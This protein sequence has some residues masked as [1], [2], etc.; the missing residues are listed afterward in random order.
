MTAPTTT[1][2]PTDFL[3]RAT[4]L[5]DRGFSTIPLKPR[6]KS[7]IGPGATS[8]TRDL[9]QIKAW[10][11]VFPADCNAAIV[12][13][14]QI[15]ILESDDVERLKSLLAECGVTLPETLTGGARENRP[16]FY[17]KRTEACGDSC[18]TVPG[19]FEFRN[20]SQYV[21]GSGSIHP[22]GHEYRF[23][24]DA[25]IAEMPA[26]LVAA[27]R[28]L[29]YDYTGEIDPERASHIQPGPYTALRAEYLRRCDPAD[30]IAMEP[31]EV[32]EG[33][34]HY[35]LQSLA[36]LLHDGERTSE[37]IVDI[38][39]DVQNHHFPSPKGEEELANIANWATRQEPCIVEPRELESFTVG[40]IVFKTEFAMETW[41]KDNVDTFSDSWE[42]LAAEELPEQ[43]TLVSLD[44]EVMIREETLTEIFAYRG[45]GKSVL[46]ASLIKILAAGGEFLGISSPGGFRVLL[47]D[48]ELPA[49]LLQK[50]LKQFVG[51]MPSNM[52][53]VRSLKKVKNRMPALAS[54]AEQHKFMQ[55]LKSWRPDVII[56]DTRTAVFKHDTNNAEQLMVVNEFLMQL[57]AEGYAVIL[58]HHAGK[59]NKQRGRTDNDDP[60]DLSI[61]LNK[62][63]NAGGGC[64]EF[65]VAFEKVRYG[66]KLEGFDAKWTPAAGWERNTRDAQI[67][68]LLL[69]GKA[70]REIIDDLGVTS[71]QIARVSARLRRQARSFRLLKRAGRPS[72]IPKLRGAKKVLGAT[73][74]NHYSPLPRLWRGMGVGGGITRSIALSIYKGSAIKSPVFMRVSRLIAL[75]PRRHLENDSNCPFVDTSGRPSTAL[76]LISKVLWLQVIAGH[77]LTGGR[78][79]DCA[80]FVRVSPAFPRVPSTWRPRPTGRPGGQ[81]IQRLR[82]WVADMLANC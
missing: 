11:E 78:H 17:F 20:K 13:D 82:S 75:G 7:P 27:L 71:D 1:A 31:V 23:W 53:R 70:Y 48:G 22:E 56:F 16:H 49:R 36:G 57:R 72:A 74:T 79:D 3:S 76:D 25:P 30:L 15:T 21:V 9:A 38:L 52:L 40:T 65:E 5:V 19:L 64:V 77:Q 51:P 62:V 80:E 61:Q 8:N 67:V 12:A 14:E 69:K 63:A 29:R 10:A 66:D 81:R 28:E 68:G 50:R 43:K 58:T 37:D 32:N 44:R 33:E 24:N 4:A 47:V 45:L 73:L 2:K 18:I 35:V 59:N 42:M 60:L 39:R 54:P 26:E 46:I 34:R 41:L 6:D 55:G